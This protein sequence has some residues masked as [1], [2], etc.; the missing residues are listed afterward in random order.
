ML[1]KSQGDSQEKKDGFKKPNKQ[2]KPKPK[3]IKT[4]T[5]QWQ[6]QTN[7]QTRQSCFTC[8]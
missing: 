6:K 4:K 5:K 1:F 3:Q 2:T 8:S 7:R